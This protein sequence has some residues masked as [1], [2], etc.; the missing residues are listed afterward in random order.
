MEEM[1]KWMLTHEWMDETLWVALC[2]ESWKSFNDPL[3]HQKLANPG[4]STARKRKQSMDW[5]DVVK[6]Q[7]VNRDDD[8]EDTEEDTEEETKADT[9][10]D[11][12]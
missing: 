2:D 9:E 4:Y 5:Y 11:T 8:E 6:K 3:Q 10:E 7:R 1:K 12:E